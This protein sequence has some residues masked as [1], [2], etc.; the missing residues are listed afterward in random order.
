MF[1]R[2]P[3]N[4]DSVIQ[5]AQPSQIVMNQVLRNTYLLLS[6]TLLVSAIS[7]F[8]SF[9]TNAAPLNIWAM[10]IGSFGLLFGIMFTRNSPV[11]I[12][13]TFLFTAFQGWVLG[14]I[15]NFYIHEFSNGGQLIMTALGS[16]G[17]IFL[18]LSGIAMNPARD[19]SHWGRFLM[20]GLIVAI[21]A[22]LLN[23]FWLKMPGMQIA[24]SLI[25]TFIFGG[26]IL[27]DTNRIVRGGETNY[28]MATVALYLDILNL[29]LNL[30][31][32]LAMFSG[33]RE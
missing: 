20:I 32:L 1:N 31:Q 10:L 33:R 22:S 13:L 3:M 19:F 8:I 12:I 30:L 23:M 29:F 16:T 27:Y 6:M 17:V 14:P 4:N 15:L 9:S 11:G 24:M 28:V 2:N 5:Q 26:F 21:V 25:F 18:V 7:A